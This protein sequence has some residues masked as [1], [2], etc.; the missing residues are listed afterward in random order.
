MTKGNL[1]LIAAL[2]GVLTFVIYNFRQ[3][4]APDAQRIAECNARVEGMPESTREE[5]NRSINTFTECL[6]GN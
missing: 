4:R 5:I 1:L 6:E 3:N 2:T